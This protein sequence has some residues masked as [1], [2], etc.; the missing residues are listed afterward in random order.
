MCRERPDEASL[1]EVDPIN[2]VS[3]V[4]MPVLMI[5]GR[6]DFFIPVETLQR[7]MF[8]LLGTPEKDKRYVLF[9]TGHAPPRTE[10]IR[11]VLDWLDRY[12][13]PVS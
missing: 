8:R 13:G 1:P 11:E 9:D 5:N 6:Y 2:F 7:P 4:R 10:S 3:R 12:L